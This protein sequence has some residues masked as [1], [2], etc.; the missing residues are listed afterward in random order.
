MSTADFQKVLVKDDRIA[1]ISDS[2]RYAIIKGGQSITAAQFKAI[3]ES[4]SSHTYN[5]QIPS[6]E[7]LVDRR[8]MWKSTVKFNVSVQFKATVGNPTYTPANKYDFTPLGYGGPNIVNLLTSSSIS[9]FPLHNLTSV[10]TSTI[11]NTSVSINM[12][13]VLSFL[14]RFYDKK[15][16]VKYNSTC[17]TQYDLTGNYNSAFQT[18][19]DTNA[20]IQNLQSDFVPRGSLQPDSVEII[21]PII[22]SPA[23]PL[24]DGTVITYQITFTSVEPLLLSPWMFNNPSNNNGALYGL[25]NL[26]F[27]MNI[28]NANRLWRTNMNTTTPV[29]APTGLGNNLFLYQSS[30][31]VSFSNSELHFMFLTPH[32]S[33]LLPSRCVSPFYEV[34]RYITP[35]N[36]T[37][38]V[39]ITKPAL[40]ETKEFMSQS[41]QLNQIPDKLIIGLRKSLASQT[42]NDPD[43]WFPITSVN[44]QFNNQAGLLSSAT[45]SDLFRMSCDAGY[46][47]SYYEWSGQAS[48]SN[49]TS[50]SLINTDGI[51]RMS[52][53]VVILDFATAI[54]L[55]ED[56]Y[57]CGS[58]GNFNLQVKVNATNNSGQVFNNPNS[59]ELVVITLNSGVFVC[60]RGTS[61]V[62]TGILSKQD[63]LDAS[64]QVAVSKGEVQR[65]VGGGFWDTLK[66]F[67]SPIVSIGKTLATPAKVILSSVPDP[68]AQAAASVLGALGAG[69]SGGGMSGGR[70]KLKDM[71]L[72]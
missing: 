55:P 66:S 5:I 41:L 6:M 36:F 4:I 64:A 7:T 60:E 40:Y 25:Q 71:R 9:P 62:Y 21:S 58:L 32:P 45:P 37:S 72:M 20:G 54:Q 44:L 52:G 43:C 61:Q 13:D 26:N 11:N 39:A 12:Q 49:K 47:G 63:V 27:V 68:R 10:L 22:P 51:V 50:G 3:S 28:G 8:V 18:L 48:Q 15:E 1:N 17:P 57:S 56:F 69:Q 31:L 34:P 2:I 23:V 30:N 65:L 33:D 46:N 70:K 59:L 24:A 35:Q 42:A 67:V 19:Y 29:P 53:S 14:L 38:A 16:L